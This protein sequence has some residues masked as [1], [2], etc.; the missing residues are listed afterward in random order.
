MAWPVLGGPAVLPQVL[1]VT[2]LDRSGEAPGVGVQLYLT[3]RREPSPGSRR[4]AF[5]MCLFR[6]RWPMESQFTNWKSGTE[7][8]LHLQLGQWPSGEADPGGTIPMHPC[9]PARGSPE[10]GR[11]DPGA[12][13]PCDRDH[14]NPS[15]SYRRDFM[16]YTKFDC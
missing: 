16:L 11:A 12:G 8:F 9:G 13:A 1:V 3:A 10:P 4:S 5:S 6:K 15:I 7:G 14:Y 2:V